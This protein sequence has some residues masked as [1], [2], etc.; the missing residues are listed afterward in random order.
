M[1]VVHPRA[2]PTEREGH[3]F[4]LML[5]CSHVCITFVS[6]EVCSEVAFK[7]HSTTAGTGKS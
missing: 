5:R 3:P 6:L 1:R 4:Y 2:R 7:P